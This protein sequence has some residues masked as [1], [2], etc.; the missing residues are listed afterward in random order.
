[1]GRTYTREAGWGSCNSHVVEIASPKLTR[2]YVLY[3]EIHELSQAIINSEVRYT[4]YEY[5]T[6]PNQSDGVTWLNVS[7]P[8]HELAVLAGELAHD[9]RSALDQLVSELVLENGNIPNRGNQFP[10][11][12]SRSRWERDVFDRGGGGVECDYCGV[13]EN[14]SSPLFGLSDA[15]VKVIE[16]SQAFNFPKDKRA[17]HEFSLLRELSNID[18][19]RSL[20]SC[21]VKVRDPRSVEYE[22]E[23]YY[24]VGEVTFHSESDLV[25]AGNEFCRVQRKILKEPPSKLFS[26]KIRVRGQVDLGFHVEGGEPVVTVQDLCRIVKRATEVTAALKP[27]LIGESP[28][29]IENTDIGDTFP[30]SV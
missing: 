9:V 25:Q 8:H 24:E 3:R 15:H 1:M 29:E 12:D 13:T 17:A 16:N 30:D 20:L 6:Y 23:G 11:Y 26:V 14:R 27:G 19:H 28:S 18:K 4:V 5:G 21:A 10:L 7:G 2:A 22:P